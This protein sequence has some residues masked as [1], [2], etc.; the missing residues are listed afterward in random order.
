MEKLGV[1]TAV[2]VTEPFVSS[3]GAMAVAHGM[4]GYP[5]AVI[6]HPIAATETRVL[7]ERADGIVEEVASMLLD[8]SA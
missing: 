8:G 1:P 2:V 4:A 3:A 5:F 6:P 7:E